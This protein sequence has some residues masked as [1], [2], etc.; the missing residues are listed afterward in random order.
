MSGKRPR[1]WPGRS[2]V[3]FGQPTVREFEYGSLAKN[4]VNSILPAPPPI[5]KQKPGN[6]NYLPFT[7]RPNGQ[8]QNQPKVPRIANNNTRRKL[9]SQ[10][11]EDAIMTNV[12][13]YPL[14]PAVVG[15]S[16]AR[17]WS[18]PKGGRRTRKRITRKRS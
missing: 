8:T 6:F 3:R 18:R 17:L 5:S 12:S 2:S 7:K 11:D 10:E 4:G 14:G 9:L 16:N 15:T 1:N 13:S